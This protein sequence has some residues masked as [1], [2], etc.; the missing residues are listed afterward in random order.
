MSPRLLAPLLVL[1]LFAPLTHAASKVY[2]EAMPAGEAQAIGAAIEAGIPADADARKF[3]GRITEVCQA[4]G[5]WVMLED[6]GQVARVMMKDHDV[7]LP[8]D[9]RGRAVVHGV[10]T[11]KVLDEKTARHLAEDAGRREPV[12]TREFRIVATSI[13]LQDG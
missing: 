5:C 10:L 6:G 8:K 4:K 12:A 11:E 7:G 1:A 9:A 3:S 2:G 13:E